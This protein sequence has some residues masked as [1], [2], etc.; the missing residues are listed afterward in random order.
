MDETKGKNLLDVI[1]TPYSQIFE[2]DMTNKNMLMLQ[3][4]KK[5]FVWI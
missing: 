3:Y 4:I 5:A 1:S 2:I